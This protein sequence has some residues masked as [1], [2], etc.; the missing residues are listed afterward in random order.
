LIVFQGKRSGK[1]LRSRRQVLRENQPGLQWMA[2]TGQ[3][4][5]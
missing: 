2:C 1:V 5:E 3:V 4:L